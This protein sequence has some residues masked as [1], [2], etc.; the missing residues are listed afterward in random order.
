MFMHSCH[1]NPEIIHL[2]T[3]IH[4]SQTMKTESHKLLVLSMFYFSSWYHFCNFFIYFF[5]LSL[6]GSLFFPLFHPIFAIWQCDNN[7]NELNAL[8]NRNPILAVLCPLNIDT[9]AFKYILCASGMSSIYSHY[10]LHK[11]LY[12]VY[13]GSEIAAWRCSCAYKPWSDPTSIGATHTGGH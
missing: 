3:L 13:S 7:E 5:S 1:Q 2:S 11:Y 12:I 8:E 9:H 4:Q 10:L 6:S